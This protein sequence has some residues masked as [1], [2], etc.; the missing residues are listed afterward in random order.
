MVYVANSLSNPI[1]MIDGHIDKIA[2]G[3]IFNIH[4]ANSGKIICNNWIVPINTYVYVQTG[5]NCMALPSKGFEF[6]TWKWSPLTNRNS[7]TPLHS[8]GNL[9]VNRNGAFTANFKPASLTIPALYVIFGA[10]VFFVAW[11]VWIKV[12]GRDKVG[13]K[14]T[15]FVLVVIPMLIFVL[16][17]ATVLFTTLKIT[18]GILPYL[19]SYSTH[20]WT[21]TMDITNFKDLIGIDLPLKNTYGIDVSPA[22]AEVVNS[23]YLPLYPYSLVTLD[24][25]GIHVKCKDP[26]LSSVP[27]AL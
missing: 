21:I 27:G 2:A 3:V 25:V 6:N 18:E 20:F 16:V 15:L 12:T 24:T 26:K 8:S 13:L 9:T 11:F 5:T 23:T 1:S 22:I 14:F 7:S 4:P 10:S 17:Y 19:L